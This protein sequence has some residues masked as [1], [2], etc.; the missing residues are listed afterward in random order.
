MTAAAAATAAALERDSH[1]IGRWASA[2]GAGGPAARIFEQT[3]GSPAL[4]Q[5]QQEELK[6]VV[7]QP[8][9]AAGI[10]LANWYWKVVHRFVW[11]RF[12]LSR[13]RSSCLNWRHRLG[14]AFK[15]LKKRLVKRNESKREAFVAE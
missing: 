5:A 14:F 7:E 12:G 3:G 2:C 4:D 11:E 8:P 13:C 1:T 10:Q 9:A 6:A 15:R